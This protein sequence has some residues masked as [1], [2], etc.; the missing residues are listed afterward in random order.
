METK[1]ERQAFTKRK[2]ATHFYDVRLIKEIVQQVE[3]G[4]PRAEIYQRYG[5][6]RGTVVRWVNKYCSEAY[7]E[8]KRKVYTPSQKRSVM[9]AIDSGMSVKEAR[10]SFG[11]TNSAVIFS[12]MKAA[13]KENDELSIANPAPMTKHVKHKETDEI[14]ALREALAFEQL[15]N[16]ALNTMIDLAEEQLKIDIRKKSGARQSSK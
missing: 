5:C 13:K 3:K 1:K 6:S 2:A 10:I 11:L 12:W 7:Q 15:K 14:K 16:K 4:T 8:L 9:R